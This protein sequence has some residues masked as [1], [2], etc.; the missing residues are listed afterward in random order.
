MAIL[1]T[2]ATFFECVLKSQV[3]AVAR[4]NDEHLAVLAP[5]GGSNYCVSHSGGITFISSVALSV[6]PCLR[7]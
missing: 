4:V 7:C 1:V 5:T 3:V 2:Y 6:C